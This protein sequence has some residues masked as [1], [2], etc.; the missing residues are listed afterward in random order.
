MY[1]MG[2]IHVRDISNAV[3]LRAA[4]V[5]ALL[6]SAL[7]FC[8]GAY[9]GD[10]FYVVEFTRYENGST[11]IQQFQMNSSV[12][13][14]YKINDFMATKPLAFIVDPNDA[15]NTDMSS[16][17]IINAIKEGMEEWNSVLATPMLIYNGTGSVDLGPTAKTSRSGF[18]SISF[19]SIPDENGKVV[20]AKTWT[21]VSTKPLENMPASRAILECD[22]LFN[23]DVLW[24]DVSNTRLEGGFDLQS[25]ATHE[26]GHTLGLGDVTNVAYSYV[27]MYGSGV[28]DST[29]QRSL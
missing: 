5:I 21:Y 27:T 2:G 20:L 10:D 7:L 26:L 4:L 12:G 8:A 23:A 16:S 11:A 29:H 14:G 17:A 28:A 18:N 15:E 22:I 24:V 3:K 13:D 9:A 1:T 6:L 19:V 25:T